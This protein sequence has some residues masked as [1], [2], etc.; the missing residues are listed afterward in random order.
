M[1]ESLELGDESFGD[2]I[3]VGAAGEVVAAE[4][5]LAIVGELARRLR[6]VELVDAELH[7]RPRRQPPPV[8]DV[9]GTLSGRD[10]APAAAACPATAA[11]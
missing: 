10:V 7:E 4:V 3:G 5:L 9:C 11:P 8:A 1:P 6:L 2:S